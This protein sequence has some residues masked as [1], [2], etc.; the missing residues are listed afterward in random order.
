MKNQR[1]FLIS[2]LGYFSIIDSIL[3]LFIFL[4][5]PLIFGKFLSIYSLPEN[6]MKLIANSLIIIIPFFIG[7]G[8]LKGEKWG[9][10]GGFVLNIYIFFICLSELYHSFG[11]KNEMDIPLEIDLFGLGATGSII[12]VLFSLYLCFY[13]TRSKVKR[14]FNIGLKT[15]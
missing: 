8:L 1:P 14:Y 5:L 10:Y 15:V 6:S 3:N 4:M 12:G 11:I 9:F 2:I 13:L 7:Y